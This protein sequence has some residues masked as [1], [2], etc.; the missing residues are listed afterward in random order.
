MVSVSTRLEKAGE[1][2]LYIGCGLESSLVPRARSRFFRSGCPVSLITFAQEE[3]GYNPTAWSC[4]ELQ[5]S[6]KMHENYVNKKLL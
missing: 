1:D 5:R 4:W 6:A 3:N 2:N